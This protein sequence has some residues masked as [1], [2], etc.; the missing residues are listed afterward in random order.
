MVGVEILGNGLLF[1]IMIYEKLGMDPAKRT[2]INQLIYHLCSVLILLNVLTMP[3][4]MARYL[5]GPLGKL[6]KLHFIKVGVR[7]ASHKIS[8]S[9][10]RIC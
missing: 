1:G 3:F 2:A 5:V 10:P 7:R 4:M 6:T 8:D 9:K